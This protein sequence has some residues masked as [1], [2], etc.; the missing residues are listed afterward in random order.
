MDDTNGLE[1]LAIARQGNPKAISTLINRQLQ[2]KEILAIISK[3]KYF[4]KEERL[5]IVFEF[6]QA[7]SKRKNPSLYAKILS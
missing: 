3:D 5:K 4:D 6:E 2:S 1:I 7:K